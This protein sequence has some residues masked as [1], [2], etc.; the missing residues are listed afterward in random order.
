MNHSLQV[1]RVVKAPLD[2]VYRAW[3][4]ASELKK[5]FSPEQLTVPEAEMEAISGGKY[6]VVMQEPGGAKHTAVGE[7]KEVVPNQKLVYSWKWEEAG[8]KADDTQMTVEF[9][10]VSDDET[11]VILTHEFFGSEEAAKEHKTGWE[12]TFNNMEK[13]LA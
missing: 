5:W 1:K 9:R 12:S 8:D 4:D 11:E 2:R 6:R 10:K 13:Y 3:T 7:F